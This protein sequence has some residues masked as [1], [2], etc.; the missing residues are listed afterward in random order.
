MLDYN[1]GQLP[2]FSAPTTKNFLLEFFLDFAL[3]HFQMTRK[4]AR[5]KGL[6]ASLQNV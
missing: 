3:L 6:L 2:F 4:S 1:N 5:L